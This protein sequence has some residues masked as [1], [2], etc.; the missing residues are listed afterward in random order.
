LLELEIKPTSG[1]RTRS[2]VVIALAAVLTA[3]LAF[4]L[5]G[6]GGDLLARRT[7][8]TTYMPDGTGLGGYSVVRVGG[9]PIGKVSRVEISGLLDPQRSVRVELRVVTRFLKNIPIDSET[10]IGTDTLVGYP[11]IDI[12]PGKSRVALPENGVLQSEPLVQADIRAD[13]LKATE[14]TFQKIS[15]LLEQSTSP[16]SQL[17]KLIYSTTEYD[18]I[19]KEVASFDRGLHEVIAPKSSLGQAFYSSVAYDDIRREVLAADQALGAIQ[20]GNGV[21]GM[22]YA[23]D[24]QYTKAVAT[25]ADLHKVLV[26]I[27]A[28]TPGS[29]VSDDETYQRITKMLAS[30]D[31]TLTSLNAGEGK[32]GELLLSPQLYES[33]NGT[34]L[35]LRSLLKDFRGDPKKYLRYQVFHK[36]K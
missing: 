35:E 21:G 11:F 29:I 22:L 12:N 14:E 30:V 19:N 15:D 34:L 17:G 1:Q 24:E 28:G 5:V 9:I 31:T 27:N 4:L 10:S 20:A 25:L 32:T 26:R 36:K 2:L 3:T 6:G 16:Q 7:T 13:Q 33:M 8:I 18:D 23:S